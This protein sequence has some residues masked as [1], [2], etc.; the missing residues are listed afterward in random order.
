MT[1]L[2]AQTFALPLSTKA[3]ENCVNSKQYPLS[4][5]IVCAAYSITISSRSNHF[6]KK[7]TNFVFS[8]VFLYCEYVVVY[9]NHLIELSL[10]IIGDIVFNHLSSLLVFTHFCST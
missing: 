1:Q 10:V 2:I 3:H 4:A 7:K 9:K 6:Q 5:C 8:V